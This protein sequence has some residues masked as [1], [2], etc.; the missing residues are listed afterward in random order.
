MSLP[1]SF[2][3]RQFL[4]TS[5]AAFFAGHSAHA[6]STEPIID[7]HQHTNYAGRPNEDLIIHQQTMGVTQTILLP[8]GTP[9]I[10]P[11][12]HEGKSNGLA[13]KAMGNDSVQAVAKEH[14]GEYFFGANEVTDLDTA[15]GEIERC[16]K[17]GAIVIGEQKFG[18]ECDSEQSQVLYQLA[19]QYNVPILMHFQTI[20]Y[21]LGYDRLYTMLEKFPKV[22]F[23]GHAQTV[24]AN[25]DKNYTV[26]Q[27]LYPKGPVVAGGLTDVMLTKYPNFHA[28]MSAGSGLNAMTRDED[29]ARGFIERHQD[30]L[31]YGSDCADI[32]GTGEKCTGAQMI[33]AIRR[34]S[35][36]KAVERKLLYENAKALFKL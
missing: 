33:A 21:N 25:I 15:R 14:P 34:L 4:A 18:V 28:D 30:K 36:S 26:E 32:V 29:H 17:L 7:I 16:L 8:A 24:W 35:P 5:S 31:I 13:A 27:G 22:H 23:I 3:R 10:R 9:L 19:E 2:S 20:T 6:A 11:S 12:T 1:R